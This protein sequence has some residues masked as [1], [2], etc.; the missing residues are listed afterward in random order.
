MRRRKNIKNKGTKKLGWGLISR[1]D[2]KVKLGLIVSLIPLVYVV[3]Y[4]VIYSSWLKAPNSEILHGIFLMSVSLIIIL[5]ELFLKYFFFC[6][7]NF[8]PD[9]DQATRELMSL[10]CNV[11]LLIG[12]VLSL[13]I[14]FFIGWF[15]GYVIIKIRGK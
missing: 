14:L 2:F 9:I 8:S 6:P 1:L 12:A 3:F 11:G 5:H 13:I 15:L 7:K 10:K 4:L